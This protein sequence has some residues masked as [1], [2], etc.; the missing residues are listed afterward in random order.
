MELYQS[1]R[2]NSIK[3]SEGTPGRVGWLICKTGI[4]WIA[5]PPVSY[6]E[7]GRPVT[8]SRPLIEYPFPPHTHNIISKDYKKTASGIVPP[9]NP[10][11]D[12]CLFDPPR[13]VVFRLNVRS[14]VN[15]NSKENTSGQACN[16]SCINHCVSILNS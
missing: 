6:H 14:R 1:I 2:L 8:A 10:F 5:V 9:D 13:S 4:G 15:I 16:Q 3:R 7:S 12:G 11:V